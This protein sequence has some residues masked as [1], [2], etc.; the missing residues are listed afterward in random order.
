MK[1]I[2]SGERTGSDS[3]ALVR[4]ALTHSLIFLSSDSAC[5]WFQMEWMRVFV[6]A[7]RCVR[8]WSPTNSCQ[9]VWR[10][11][12]DRGLTDT[13]GEFLMMIKRLEENIEG[14]RMVYESAVSD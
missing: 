11:R 12:R 4:I 14:I 2:G 1:A 10:W 7:S 5:G 3:S 9:I 13:M 6:A 8:N